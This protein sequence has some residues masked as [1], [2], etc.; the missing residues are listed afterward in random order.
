MPVITSP[1]QMVMVSERYTTVCFQCVLLLLRKCVE[2]SAMHIVNKR[3]KSALAAQIEMIPSCPANLVHWEISLGCQC[4]GLRR[5]QSQKL[6]LGSWR[7]TL[8]YD[9]L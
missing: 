2:M 8:A 5:L 3:I 7:T 1:W 4:V 6:T 9:R